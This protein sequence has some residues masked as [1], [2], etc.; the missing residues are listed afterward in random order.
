MRVSVVCV[1]VALIVGACGGGGDATGTTAGASLPQATTTAS[2]D[3]ATTVPA[4]TTTATPTTIAT[5]TTAATTTTTAAPVGAPELPVTPVVGSF[6]APTKW[7]E[8]V[9]EATVEELGFDPSGI[10]LHWYR[11]AT[12]ERWIVVFVGLDLA[13]TG[14]LCPTSS[15][16][17]DGAQGS[18]FFGTS[19]TPGAD[20]DAAPV[21]LIDPAAGG[22]RV[23]DGVVSLLTLI[24]AEEPGQL[25]GGLE[26]YPEGGTFY[27]VGGNVV[28][29]QSA[30]FVDPAMLEC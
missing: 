21:E 11:D 12:A 7:G 5:T 1:G 9:G 28:A 22:V 8:E 25:Y 27:S 20:C 18:K 30:P 2:V 17:G 6:N 14:A 19:A 23:C 4:V 15:F 29:D 3:P 10:E 16:F 24:P 13:S 26:R